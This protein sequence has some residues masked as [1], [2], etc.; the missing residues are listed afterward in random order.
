MTVA[1]HDALILRSKGQRSRWY[2]YKVCCW[3]WMHVDTTA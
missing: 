2:S 3:C 1:W